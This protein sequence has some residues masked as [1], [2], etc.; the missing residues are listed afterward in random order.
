MDQV[1]E[2]YQLATRVYNI[3]YYVNESLVT[4]IMLSSTFRVLI[5]LY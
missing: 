3:I 1:L 2:A 4:H 5:A